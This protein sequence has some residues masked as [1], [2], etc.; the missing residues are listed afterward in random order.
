MKNSINL[1]VCVDNIESILIA[2]K[3]GVD[4]L[5]LCGSLAVGGITPSVG[6]LKYAK[7]ITDISLHSMI[8]TRDGD[9]CFSNEEVKGM[10]Y[11]VDLFSNLGVH[12]IVIGFLNA[13]FSI[14][15]R[16]TEKF[17]KLAK[18]NNLCVT[19]HRAIDLAKDYRNSVKS[20]ID[21]GVDRILTSG[22]ADKAIAGLDKIFAV[23]REFGGKITVMAGSGITADNV[24]NII[25]ETRVKDIHCSAS[26]L[27]NKFSCVKLS[28]GSSASDLKYQITDI[29][30]LKSIK[31]KLSQYFIEKNLIME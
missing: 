25:R 7:D 6:L 2:D 29:N 8:R 19:F 9:F 24:G 21:I 13:D 30:K 23:N 5:E 14:D 4:R 20:L 17:V 27:V 16:T 18:Q 28:L 31:E 15:L 11:D 12:G 10:E 1:E 22:Q 26:G 3:V